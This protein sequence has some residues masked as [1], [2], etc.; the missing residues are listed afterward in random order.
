MH[1]MMDYLSQVS[2]AS[3]N[4]FLLYWNELKLVAAWELQENHPQS[5]IRSGKPVCFGCCGT[6]T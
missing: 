3:T 5:T 6:Q 4:I 2:L 1:S